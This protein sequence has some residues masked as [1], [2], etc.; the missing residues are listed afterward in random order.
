MLSGIPSRY[1]DL[2]AST[3][4]SPAQPINK[5][6]TIPGYDFGT[7]KWTTIN[8]Q[9]PSSTNNELSPEVAALLKM[10]GKSKDK[11]A[12][13]TEP[14]LI[15]LDADNPTECIPSNKE[16]VYDSVRDSVQP[17][18]ELV[19]SDDS[20]TELLNELNLDITA[21]APIVISPSEHTVNLEDKIPS[22]KLDSHGTP[23]PGA[24][25]ATKTVPTS[26]INAQTV[27]PMKS[28]KDNIGT[29][30]CLDSGACIVTNSNDKKP[31]TGDCTTNINDEPTPENKME[32]K[33]PKTEPKLE[34]DIEVEL[35][36]FKTEQLNKLWKV[37]GET[38]VMKIENPALSANFIASIGN[39]NTSLSL[40]EIPN[41]SDNTEIKDEQLEDDLTYTVLDPR[42]VKTL[43]KPRPKRVAQRKTS[44]QPVAKNTLTLN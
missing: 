22:K 19:S 3:S 13:E 40:P 15:E 9:R 36:T 37:P 20:T 23:Q 12:T 32:T 33:L 7:T 31:K 1:I 26:N 25:T 6:A 35:K 16:T 2:T 18:N 11:A 30:D 8:W 24:E 39:F 38:P 17:S 5:V 14:E 10:L 41:T 43:S 21:I 34:T 29:S 44:K 27:N 42:L 28:F 4:C